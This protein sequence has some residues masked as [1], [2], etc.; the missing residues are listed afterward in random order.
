[1]NSTSKAEIFTIEG[2]L[3][4]SSRK[5]AVRFFLAVTGILFLRAL[6][7]FFSGYILGF[8]RRGKL[9]RE[10]STL[11]LQEERFMLGRKIGTRE[12]VVPLRA[13]LW[14]RRDERVGLLYVLS[15]AL[16]LI[17]GMLVGF[18]FFV[19]WSIT[20]LG[21]YLIIGFGCIL[22]GIAVDIAVSFLLPHV[23][24]RSSLSFAT[25]TETYH[26]SGVAEDKIDIFLGKVNAHLRMESGD[27]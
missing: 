6:L 15:A 26:L 23:R 20:L 25:T 8:R 4:R 18:V 17:A 16:G 9:T 27:Q 5:K 7:L 2:D 11:R 10:G 24:K 14:I 19:E 22:G 13:I 21:I 12:T 3:V 1:M